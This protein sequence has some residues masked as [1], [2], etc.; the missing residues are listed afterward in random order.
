[1][2]F[3]RLPGAN[4]NTSPLTNIH[5]AVVPPRPV[6]PTYE[7]VMN[8]LNSIMPGLDPVERSRRA[9]AIQQMQ[10]QRAQLPLEKAKIELGMQEIPLQQARINFMKDLYSGGE[11]TGGMQAAMKRLHEQGMTMDA[12]GGIRPLNPGELKTLNDLQS[13]QH[14]TSTRIRSAA[15]VINN[16]PIDPSLSAPEST[17]PSQSAPD[18]SGQQPTGDVDTDSLFNQTLGTEIPDQTNG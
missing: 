3:D 9:M 7:V 16:L 2:P 13:T 17:P 15:P 14:G 10:L 4:L 5:W 18:N 11:G 1:M 6:F 8:A 12:N